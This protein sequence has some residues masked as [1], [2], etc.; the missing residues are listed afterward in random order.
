MQCELP[1]WPSRLLNCQCV[2]PMHVWEL[3]EL[4]VDQRG[5]HW[6]LQAGTP[7]RNL[8][9][10]MIGVHVKGWDRNNSK[11][12]SVELQLSREYYQVTPLLYQEGHVKL[13]GYPTYEHL[14][15]HIAVAW[16]K[17]QMFKWRNAFF[18]ISHL[19]LIRRVT[20]DAYFTHSSIP[21]LP[22]PTDGP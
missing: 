1:H 20:R 6:H 2:G 10:G 17:S 18:N 12:P 4:R 13:C 21:P 7:R 3:H 22:L 11:F 16:V 5:R 19:Q 15:T 8:R 14:N 9:I